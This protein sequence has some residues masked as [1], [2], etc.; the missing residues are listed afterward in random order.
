MVKKNTLKSEVKTINQKIEAEN[1]K[2]SVLQV[3]YEEA[4]LHYAK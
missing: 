3:E 1:A 4:K 2:L